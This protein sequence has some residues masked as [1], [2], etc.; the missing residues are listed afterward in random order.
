MLSSQH[1]RLQ[2]NQE[3]CIEVKISLGNTYSKF[4]DSLGY[5]VKSCLKKQKQEKRREKKDKVI[6]NS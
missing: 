1:G 4:W 5:I 6:G 3:N 2:L